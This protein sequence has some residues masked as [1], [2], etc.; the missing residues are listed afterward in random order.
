MTEVGRNWSFRSS[1]SLFHQEKYF[2]VIFCI[3]QSN[4][5]TETKTINQIQDIDLLKFSRQVLK[6]KLTYFIY[7]RGLTPSEVKD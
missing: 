7:I 2:Y 1:L 3:Q 5:T 4:E 6:A